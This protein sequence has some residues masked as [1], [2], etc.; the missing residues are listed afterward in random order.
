M[1]N[2]QN[3]IPQTI[4]GRH[5]RDH[6]TRYHCLVSHWN[7]GELTRTKRSFLSNVRI[8]EFKG[9]VTLLTART[10]LFFSRAGLVL[11]VCA[12]VDL[13]RGVPG[14]GRLCWNPERE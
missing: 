5:G 11:V 3:Q 8:A 9:N 7:T 14:R 6:P 12:C 4:S 1:R 10:D 13:L 2:L